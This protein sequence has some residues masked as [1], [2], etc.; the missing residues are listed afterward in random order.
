M[1]RSKVKLRSQHDA[2]YLH[3]LTNVLPSFNLLHLTV[4]VILSGQD[5]KGQ[6]HYTKFKGQVTVMP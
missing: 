4:S 6:G 2:A 5:C 1:A 3:F